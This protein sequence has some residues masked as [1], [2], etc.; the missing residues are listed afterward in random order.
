M[1]TGAEGRLSDGDGQLDEHLVGV[2]L[3]IRVRR[4]VDG[5]DEIA[6]RRTAWAGRTGAADA[7][8]GAFADSRWDGDFNSLGRA[9]SSHAQGSLASGG[10]GH[11]I[12]GKLLIN[13]P[14]PG[15]ARA[16]AS[17]SPGAKGP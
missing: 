1:D 2:A 6:G 14:S 17:M 13:V 15:R 8:L 9:A 7:E 10:G 16:C 11:E 5:K 12:D 4:D 3:E